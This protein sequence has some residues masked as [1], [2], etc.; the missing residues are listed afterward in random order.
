MKKKPSSVECRDTALALVFLLLLIWLFSQN[1]LFIYISMVFT[2]WAMI[3]PGTLSPLASFWLGLSQLLGRV[4]S[5]VV[6]TVIYGLVVLPMALIRRFV[7]RKD[8]L[9]LRAWRDG[10]PSAFV[11]RDHTFSQD[12]LTNPF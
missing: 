2:L 1:N 8:S 11:P 10:S 4:M 12:D 5:K 9:R 6:L 7:L 3:F